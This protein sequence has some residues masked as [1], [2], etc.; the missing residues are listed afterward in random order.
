MA[1]LFQASTGRLRR[2]IFRGSGR[3]PP[4]DLE[5]RRF[6][7]GSASPQ[8]ERDRERPEDGKSQAAVGPPRRYGRTCVGDS[9]RHTHEQPSLYKKPRRS[10]RGFWKP[11]Q[12]A[13]QG[14]R[15][16]HPQCRMHRKSTSSLR[17]KTTARQPGW[18]ADGC[19]TARP[20]LSPARDWRSGIVEALV[21]AQPS[22]AAVRRDCRSA[23]RYRKRSWW[24]DT[25]P[26]AQSRRAVKRWH[27]HAADLWV[28]N[29]AITAWCALGATQAHVGATYALSRQRVGQIVKEFEWVQEAVQE[30]LRS[31]DDSDGGGGGK[32]QSS[33]RGKGGSLSSGLE[34]LDRCSGEFRPLSRPE[35]A[36]WQRICDRRGAGLRRRPEGCP[37]RPP[38]GPGRPARKVRKV[39]KAALAAAS[40]ASTGGFPR[41]Q[42]GKVPVWSPP[43]LGESASS[44][45]AP[46]GRKV[47][48]L[49]LAEIN[50]RW[51]LRGGERWR[52]RR[53]S[54]LAR[55]EAPALAATGK[56]QH[57]GR[58][59]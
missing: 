34:S 15:Q 59:W 4:G 49:T 27:G 57:Q 42:G 21:E 2:P 17:L 38:S 56:Y 31:L 26:P 41:S 44:G 30:R 58:L 16:R 40:L 19:R 3:N 53:L 32:C 52:Q 13:L 6:R 50:R 39:D 25:S 8:G 24:L 36:R 51:R 37:A 28:R 7:P 43:A 11:S 33:L 54:F 47:P 23:P 5:A 46:R 14:G 20:G 9:V 45:S 18:A 22:S 35:R 12:L 1:G 48:S 55:P 10:G 29:V